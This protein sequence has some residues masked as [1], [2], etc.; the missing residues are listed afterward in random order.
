[1][2]AISA[3]EVLLI[4]SMTAVASTMFIQLPK[5]VNTMKEL[6][7]LSSAT[8]VAKDIAG[9]IITSIASPSDIT[10]L[11]QFPKDITYTS[12]IKDNYVY[13]TA[14]SDSLTIENASAKTLANFEVL[15]K[16]AKVLQVKKILKDNQNEYEVKKYG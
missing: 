6:T 14:T 2:K 11:Y 3:T 15:I 4:V 5:E 16:D 12:S 13:V 1:M 9:L 10:L 8:A 7:V